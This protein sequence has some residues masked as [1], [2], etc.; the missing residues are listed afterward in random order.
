MKTIPMGLR[1]AFEC[2][3]SRLPVGQ[4]LRQI[5]S[6][7]QST[8][9]LSAQPRSGYSLEP[10]GCRFGY[11]GKRERLILQPQRG[12]GPDVFSDAINAPALRLRRIPILPPRVA[13]AATLG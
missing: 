8:C 2:D 6:S 5:K 9:V 11:P 3:A 4:T 7:E 10:R 1:T 12:A 13:A